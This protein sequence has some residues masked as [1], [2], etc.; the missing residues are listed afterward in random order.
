MWSI[1]IRAPNGRSGATA[2]GEDALF[3]VGW[4]AMVGWADREKVWVR[5]ARWGGEEIGPRSEICLNGIWF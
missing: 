5:A 1:G 4:A 2:G 3:M